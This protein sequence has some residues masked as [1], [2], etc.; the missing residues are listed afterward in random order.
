M[1]PTIILSSILLSGIASASIQTFEGDGFGDWQAQGTAFGLSPVH[2]KLD[3]M[4]DG[5]SNFAND[6]FAL[7]AH[8]GNDAVG[9]LTSPEITLDKNYLLF[10]I[11]GGN[12]AGKTA[13]QLLIDDKVVLE[14]TGEKSQS[15]TRVVW[16][17]TKFKGKSAV[18][19]LVDDAN[20]EWGYI[21]ADH[22][23][24]DNYANQKFPSSTKKGKPFVEGLVATPALAGAII[25][26]GSM[27]AI[28]ATYKSHGVKSPTALTFDDKGN[29][30]LAE[31]HRFRAGIE[32]DRN[33]LYWYLDDLQA[34]KTEDRRALHKKWEKKLSHAYMTKVT[35]VVRKLSDTNGDG[36]IDEAKVFA[37]GF[38]DVLDGTA[39]GIF[40]YD[41]AIYFACIP[42][43]YKMFDANGDDVADQKE[44][45]Q[46]GFGVRISLSG[47]DMN[48]FTLGPDG[49]IYG[50]IGDRGF[51][52][53]TKEGK[54]YHYPNEGALFRFEPD[55]S[56]FEIVHTGLRNPKEI[57]FDEL[58]NA[59]TVDNNSDQGDA[60]RIV[61][62]VEGGD[63]GW[64]MEHQAMHTFHRQIGLE[65]RPLS[66]WMDEKM[67]EMEN[68]VQPAYILPPSAL[69]TSGPSGLTYHPGAGFLESEKGRFLICDYKGG[70]SNSGIWSFS[71][72][73]SGAG[74]RMVDARQFNWGVAATDVEYSFDGRVFVSD[75]VNGW[76]SHND[77]RLLSISAGENLYLPEETRQAAKLIAEGFDQ[78]ESKELGNLLGHADSRVRLRAQVALTRKADAI[79]TF[80]TA[81]NSKDLITRIHGVWGMGIIARRG[82]TP[83]PKG[84]FAT[85]EN[86][87]ALRKKAAS[88]LIPLLKDPEPEIRVQTLRVIGDAPV[89]PETL[90][91]ASLLNDASARVR[92]EAAI[93]IGK[94]KSHQDFKAITE[95]IKT[96]NNKDRYLRHAGIYA[97]QHIAKSPGELADLSK[98]DSPVVRLAAVVALRRMHSTEL[99]AFLQDTDPKVQDETIRAIDDLDMIELKKLSAALLEQVDKRSWQPMILRRLVNHAYRNGTP[100]DAQR[101]ITIITNPKIDIVVKEEALRLLNIW[102]KP[103]PVDP[104]SGKWRPLDPRS[105]D[106]VKAAIT[107]NIAAL[108]KAEDFVI[109]GT[110]TLAET[111]SLGSDVINS[112]TLHSFIFNEKLIED[113]R[114]KALEIYIKRNEKDLIDVLAKSAGDSSDMLS[115]TALQ[116]AAKISPEFAIK[117]LEK[118]IVSGSAKRAQESWAILAS[119]PDP[120]A[121]KFIADHLKKLQTAQGISP[122]AIELLAAAK[123]RKEPEV[124]KALKDYEAHFAK[125]TDTYA[126]YNIALEGGDPENGL[127]LFKSLPTGQCMR[128]HKSSEKLNAPGGDAGPNLAG[129]GKLHDRKYLLQ[130]LVNPGAAVAPGYGITVVNFKNGASLSGNLV[131][132]N[133]DH[134][135]VSTPDKTWSVKRA[136]ITSFTPP[137]SA[138]PPMAGVVKSEELRDLVA[139]LASLETQA[140][141]KK[142]AKVDALD[143][144]TLPGAK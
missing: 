58:G 7:S 69:L 95:F 117:A 85:V 71:M 3:G 44:V 108:L 114:A 107:K 141:P 94:L 45:I 68:D 75:F 43:I 104:V 133:A 35:E 70:A 25:P 47:H 60:A 48:G 2:A 98:S 31:T 16:D 26:K 120:E 19:R 21:A 87:E 34:M 109:T 143:P 89:A 15:F 36:K 27:M 92:F 126:Q 22:F 63:T 72:E 28:E 80:Q 6:A 90:S 50:T 144:A 84:E 37:N 40:Y 123:T 38:N 61:Y 113:A 127:L 1:K 139:W 24:L 137:I 14:A 79:E 64:Q 76:Q 18:I 102:E 125:Q 142:P 136:D 59:I 12:T 93:A 96:N 81:I 106:T 122:S 132:E 78:R 112:G 65:N 110:L 52:I 53:T 5:F 83:N 67:W 115:L 74:M 124:Q 20:G 23:V 131:E 128:C 55:G 101:I 54:T 49:R 105:A 51:S 130:S 33:H 118:T 82:V 41:G 140:Q 97:L 116:G 32:D 39:A 103:H 66:R 77:G 11:A 56:N 4:K 46:D 62:L 121:A 135:V 100:E 8:G 91:L 13:V 42:K 57:A 138:M 119:I 10:L 86:L 134:I 73:P 99:K 29:V 88:A 111:Y 17:V 9:T 129:V 30:Y